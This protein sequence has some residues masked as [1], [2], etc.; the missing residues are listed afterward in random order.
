MLVQGHEKI[1]MM[2]KEAQAIQAHGHAL[3]VGFRIHIR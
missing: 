1:P 3:E 2:L